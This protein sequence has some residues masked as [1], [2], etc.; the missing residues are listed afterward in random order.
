MSLVTLNLALMHLM[1][2]G[3]ATGSSLMDAAGEKVGMMIYAPKT[4]NVRKIH[5]RTGTVTTWQNLTV[6]FQGGSSGLPDGSF[7]HSGTA[8]GADTDDNAWKAVTL[9]VDKGVTRGDRLYLAFE[10]AST[11]GNLN[12][13][14]NSALYRTVFPALYT[15]S[16]AR[17][18]GAP[19]VVLEYDDGSIGVQ[20]GTYPGVFSGTSFNSGST[21]DERALYFQQAAPMQIDGAVLRCAIDAT[22]DFDIVLYDVA[23]NVLATKSVSGND[24]QTTSEGYAFVPFGSVI[25]LSASTVYRLAFKPTTVNNVVLYGCT[26][27]SAAWMASLP[28]GA[29]WYSSTRTNGGAWSQ[30]TTE[31]PFIHPH[32][33]GMDSGGGSGGVA[34]L[35]GGGL[36]K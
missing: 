27:G 12:I 7:S 32:I 23:D 21:P 34:S 22:D 17:V 14:Y 1:A 13:N 18:A 20:E 19:L 28:G 33:V 4:G 3:S 25:D 15:T 9:S 8:T 36:V 6:G 30:T 2:S 10:W 26:V 31:R 16:W 5:F 24:F 35:V 29:D 11:A